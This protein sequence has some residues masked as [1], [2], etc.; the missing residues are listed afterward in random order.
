MFEPRS[1]SRLIAVLVGLAL[2][3]CAY[4]RAEPIATGPWAKISAETAAATPVA[5]PPR[6]A[7]LG[8]GDSFGQTL[9]RQYLASLQDA[10][11]AVAEASVS[12]QPSRD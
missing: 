8:A 2:G 9:Y 3:G 7:Y 12:G 1:Q 5:S 10:D 6:I 4:Q 11:Q